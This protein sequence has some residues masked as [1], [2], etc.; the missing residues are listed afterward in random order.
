VN[1]ISPGFTRT[2]GTEGRKPRPGRASMDEEFAEIAKLQPIRRVQV[3]DDLAGVVSFLASDDSAF[4][5]GQT[6]YVD[7]GM[8]RV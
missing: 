3:P 8:V 6:L 7:G 4:M 1:A 5:T 2:P